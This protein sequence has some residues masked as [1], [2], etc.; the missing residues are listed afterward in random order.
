MVARLLDMHD[1]EIGGL[2]QDTAL[3]ASM[4]TTALQ[5]AQSLHQIQS[6]YQDWVAL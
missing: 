4:A 2:G 3:V 1:R 6:A 5:A